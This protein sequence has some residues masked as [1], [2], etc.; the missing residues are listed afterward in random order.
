MKDDDAK[1]LSIDW[2]RIADLYD[3]YVQTTFDI[4]FFLNEARKTSGEAL[5]LMSGTGR[6]SVP[7]IEA[8]VRL[9]CVDA[10]LEMLALLREKLTRRRVAAPVHQM[11]VRELALQKQFDL[12]FI[13]F[14]SFS[15]LLSPS[16]QRK[17]FVC[18][19]EHLAETGRF[20]CTLHN[21][22]VRL[23]RVDGQLRLW[24]KYPLEDRQGTLLF[25]GLEN[26]DSDAHIVSGLEFFEEYDANGVMQSKRAVEL[27]FRI[28][29]KREFEDLAASVGFKIAALYGDYSYSEF[30]EDTSPFMIW[31]LKDGCR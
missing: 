26:Y 18:I 12:I 2:A 8:G 20:I 6:V 24:G 28:V 11:D 25:W 19:H 10:S 23:K 5:E 7:L 16:D 4:P 13:P 17:A 29:E 30:H 21:P 27:C 14:Q 9:T 1:S 31:V 3:T 15:E 22:R